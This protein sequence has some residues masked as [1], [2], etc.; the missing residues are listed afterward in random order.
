[1][2]NGRNFALLTLSTVIMHTRFNLWL[3]LSLT[4]FLF[5]CQSAPRY[6]TYEG[7][8]MGTYYKVSFEIPENQVLQSEIDSVLVAVNKSMSTYIPESTISK[9]NASTLLSIVK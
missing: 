2:I 5:S 1:M 9:F 4:I 8:T 6:Q 7:K 3:Y